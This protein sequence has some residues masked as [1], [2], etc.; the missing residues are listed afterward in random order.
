[1]HTAS[2]YPNTRKNRIRTTASILLALAATQFAFAQATAEQPA[3]AKPAAAPDAPKE[4]DVVVMEAFNVTGGFR[5]SLAAATEEKQSQRL[6]TEVIQAEDIGKLPD[7][8]IA[9]SLTRLP[10]VTTQRINGRAQAVVIRGMN[11]DFSTALLNGRQQVSTSGGRSVEFDQYPAELLN[12]VVVYKSTDASLTGQGLSGTVDLQ[13]IRP[14][15]K[16]GRALGMN[17]FYE[18]T[19]MSPDNAG[20]KKGAFRSTVS[21]VDQFADNTVGIAIGVSLSKRP[22]QGQQFNAWGYDGGWPNGANLLGGAKPFVRS[23]EIDR[24]GYMAVIEL[25]PNENFHSTLDLFYTDFSETQLLRGIEMP[26]SPNWGT[27]TSLTPGYTVVNGLITKA[28][29]TNFFGV[30]RNDFVKRDDNLFAGGW[31]LEFGNK[32][33]WKADLD[34]SFSHVKRTDFVLETYSGYGVNKVGTPD[35]IGYTLAPDGAAGAVFTHTLD[36]SDGAKMRLGMPQGWGSSSTRPYGQHGF[37]KGPIARDQ[38]AQIKATVQHPLSGIFSRFETGL[39]WNRRNK[40]ETESGP[41]GM[42]GYFLQLKNGVASAAMPASVGLTDLSFIGMGKMYSYDPMALYNSGTYDKIA[43]NDPTLMANNYNVTEKVTTFHTKLDIQTKLA[44]KTLDGN[45]GFQAI[46]TDQSATGQAVN[47]SSLAITQVSGGDKYWDVVPSLNLN[48]HITDKDAL[49]FSLARQLARQPMSD[50][51]A[52]STYSFDQS[53]ATA[54][55]LENSP[56]SASGGNTALKPWRSNSIDMSFEHYFSDNMGYWSVAA[57]Y[58]DLVSYTYNARE[59]MDFTGLPTGATGVTPA[60]WQ[61]YNNVPKNGQGG[62]IKGLEFAISLPGE[63]FTPMLKGF[64]VVGSTSFFKSSIQP[65]LGNPSTPLVGLSDK[66]TSGTVYYERGGFSVR[67]SIRYRSA[68]RGDIA[69]FGP[70]GAV[71][72]NLQAET[73]VDAQVSYAWKKGALKGLTLIAQ[74]YNL[75]DEPMSA[76]SGADRRFVQDY[77]EYGTNYSVGATYKF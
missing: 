22:G 12:S 4:S 17:G 34:L 36:Y 71:Y 47:R 32:K 43:N 29:L 26:L 50:M 39:N 37:L 21:Y 33:G 25:A 44:G 76:S 48:L 77:Q 14:L 72:R 74:A 49:R 10:G 59:V 31:K 30:V 7:I 40:Y 67:T 63:K 46:H 18:W 51:R 66:V 57:F 73:V 53:K 62:M 42:E 38:I 64:G 28:T 70:R 3:D 65:D 8:S 13:T 20:A 52:G 19:S 2:S 41:N 1:M 6:I 61:G 54:T 69:T 68:F 60:I 9:E 75:T 55:T 11:G 58:K 56:W 23:S 45:I 5:D 35:T 16:G 15:K 24:D 27:G